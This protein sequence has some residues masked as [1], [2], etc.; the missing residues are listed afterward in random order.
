MRIF[1]LHL[2]AVLLFTLTAC[3]SLPEGITPV[4]NFNAN[5]YLGK[6][7]E[8]ARIDNGFEKD[9]TKVS[10]NYSLRSDGGIDVLNRGYNT[11]KQQWSDAKGKAY[12]V[13]TPHQG[14]LKVSFFGPFY[15][16]YVVFELAEDYSYSF[17]TGNDRSYLWL[18]SRTPD[19]SAELKQKFLKKITQLGFNKDE[20]IFVN[21][22]EPAT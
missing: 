13:N 10:A 2:V 9:L 22:D 16:S 17:V 1:K 14:H 21:H 6:W 18:L 15:G 3:V 20:L 12:L 5:K 7:Y 8:V 11:R 19:I 4:N